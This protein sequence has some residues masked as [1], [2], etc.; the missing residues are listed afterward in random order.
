MNRKPLLL[1]SIRPETLLDEAGTS[2]KLAMTSLR[3][4]DSLT[5]PSPA[6]VGPVDFLA[7]IMSLERSWD[8]GWV[9]Q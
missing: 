2:S 5:V 1:W 3:D 4:P 7:F 6:S 9:A 8:L